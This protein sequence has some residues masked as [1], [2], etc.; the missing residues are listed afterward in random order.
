MLMPRD[1][2]SHI[3]RGPLLSLI[4]DQKPV[5][6]FAGESLAAALL[7]LGITTFNR[8]AS[9]QPR[10]PFCNMGTCFECQVQ[11]ATTPDSEFR[12][13]RACMMAVRDGMVIKTGLSLHSQ[14]PIPANLGSNLDEPG[15]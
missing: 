11:I 1:H 8:T 15:N 7:A 2:S 10:G 5:Q 6:A 13:V 4:V 12:W 3:Q 9:G 14:P